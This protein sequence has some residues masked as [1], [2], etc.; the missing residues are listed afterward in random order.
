M[1]MNL[2]DLNMSFQT[3]GTDKQQ[4]KRSSLF[5]SY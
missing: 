2:K 5:Q 3:S 4:R 1:E